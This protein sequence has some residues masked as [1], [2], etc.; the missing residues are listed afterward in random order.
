MGSSLYRLPTHTP[1][2]FIYAISNAKP[3]SDI[4]LSFGYFFA[5]SCFPPLIDSRIMVSA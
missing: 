5:P 1:L 4:V 2:K 3:A